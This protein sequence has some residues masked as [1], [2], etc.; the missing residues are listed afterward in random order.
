MLCSTNNAPEIQEHYLFITG[1]CNWF[2]CGISIINLHEQAH[3]SHC[4]LSF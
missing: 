4:N 3:V 2:N 1:Y